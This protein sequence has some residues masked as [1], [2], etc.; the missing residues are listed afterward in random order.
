MLNLICPGRTCILPTFNGWAAKPTT[1]PTSKRPLWLKSI[2]SKSSGETCSIVDLVYLSQCETEQQKIIRDC[3][4][5]FDVVES[6][7]KTTGE[8]VLVPDKKQKK[9][10]RA[11][12]IQIFNAGVRV[13]SK[14]TGIS[15]FIYWNGTVYVDVDS[16]VFFANIATIKSTY[17]YIDPN[18]QELFDAI[19]KRLIEH[20]TDIFLFSQI[21][22]SNTSFHFV[23]SYNIEDKD[24]TIENFKFLAETAQIL[25]RRNFI[26]LGKEKKWL[27]NNGENILKKMI[28]TPNVLDNCSKNPYQPLFISENPIVV[29]D[30][31]TGYFRCCSDSDYNADFLKCKNLIDD[32][33][34]G[35]DALLKSVRSTLPFYLGNLERIYNEENK[36]IVN[37]ANTGD[38][39]KE[40]AKNWNLSDGTLPE[41]NDFR[42]VFHYNERFL[43]ATTLK[44]YVG[45][46]ETRWRKIHDM[47]CEKH[48]IPYNSNK[49]YDVETLKTNFDFYSLDES[50]ANFSVLEQFGIYVTKKSKFYGLEGTSINNFQANEVI[51][52]PNGNGD[53]C[54]LSYYY[55]KIIDR[56]KYNNVI[57][58]KAG[59]G[60]G[61]STFYREIFQKEERVMIVS[62]LKS[63]RDGVYNN[64][65]FADT[66]KSNDDMLFDITN[67]ETIN[68]IF[69]YSKIKKLIKEHEAL[70]GK[71]I[72]NWDTY[73]LIK[74]NYG[75]KFLNQY[76]KCFDESHN[77]VTAANYRNKKKKGFEETLISS[78]ID[79]NTKNLLICSGTP[80]YEWALFDNVYTFEFLK[81]DTIKYNAVFDMCKNCFDVYKEN[82]NIKSKFEA[83]ASFLV[84]YLLTN[85]NYKDFD[86]TILFTNVYNKYI[87]HYME[88]HKPDDL[89]VTYFNKENCDKKDESCLNIINNNILKDDIMVS[90]IFGSQG[91]EI[92]NDI[93]SLLA[94]FVPGE[95]TKTDIIQ[96]IHR[97]R[98]VKNITMLFVDIPNF[99]NDFKGDHEDKNIK[100]TIDAL[101]NLTDYEREKLRVHDNW[102]LSKAL[103]KSNVNFDKQD[104]KLA[105]YYIKYYFNDRASFQRLQ[106][107]FTD[108]DVAFDVLET[109]KIDL[110]KKEEELQTPE[111][112]KKYA[113]YIIRFTPELISYNEETIPMKFADFVYKDLITKNNLKT[114]NAISLYLELYNP[115]KFL[116]NYNNC[117]LSK[118][119]KLMN[120]IKNI[121]NKYGWWSNEVNSDIFLKPII[122]KLCKA[123]T[124]VGEKDGFQSLH[125]LSL[126]KM[127]KIYDEFYIHT[128]HSQYFNNVLGVNFDE[129]NAK[130]RLKVRTLIQTFNKMAMINKG[131]PAGI[132]SICDVADQFEKISLEIPDY[133][134][135]KGNNWE[136]LNQ[137]MRYIF[138][139]SGFNP[140]TG[141]PGDLM[142]QMYNAVNLYEQPHT[143][144]IKL[145][146]LE[147]NDGV[148]D[149]IK[150]YLHNFEEMCEYFMNVFWNEIKYQNVEQFIRKYKFNTPSK[151]TKG[152]RVGK[153]IGKAVGKAVGKAKNVEFVLQTDNQIKF[154]SLDECYQ[155][156]VKQH[157]GE[158]VYTETVFKK[159]LKWK[160]YFDKIKKSM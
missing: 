12:A 22:S 35:N 85:T 87:S 132:L 159:K 147:V 9:K 6:F 31:W 11:Y 27:G 48:Y 10:S 1:N 43:I 124:Y 112:K 58:I 106:K 125:L 89:S 128:Q 40:I 51:H 2:S 77:I 15:V 44:A 150:T 79:R 90:T 73:Q 45:C 101:C 30:K 122:T 96:T 60:V 39:I 134:N 154:N 111:T 20:C 7:N 57:Y 5:D 148:Y 98:Q 72:I 80:Q 104:V 107:F 61:K 141:E 53:D 135:F 93:N 139:K 70:P 16:K 29:N 129:H 76:V 49:I 151:S 4:D 36:K 91:I 156:Y 21:S 102:Q 146:E 140:K 19:T 95:T 119:L 123:F 8:P 33:Y 50:R 116:T 136:I 55:D 84:N 68:Y 14:I 18:I 143:G 69:D 117:M 158:S 121:I 115:R 152:Q 34:I 41:T 67:V 83:A 92:K 118:D 113:D 38:L 37:R 157:E 59:C 74:E 86:K 133:K 65:N 17:D 3:L 138:R 54:F 103:M 71:L 46:D 25:V 120:S 155:Y 142:I 28:D 64:N 13:S 130:I 131:I 75:I 144:E 109:K 126:Y 81:E 82:C 97:F 26:E 47:F 88:Q 149:N 78:I 66:D 99:I 94:I 42:K 160:L 32:S 145:Y 56:L 127:L 114:K 52:L 137:M 23:F 153:A 108:N 63:I 24:K 110:Y 62:H 105:Y 100:N